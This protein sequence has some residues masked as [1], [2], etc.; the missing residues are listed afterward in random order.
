LRAVKKVKI[1]WEGEKSVVENAAGKL[2]DLARGFFAAGRELE[3]SEPPLEDL[4]NFRLLTK[5]FRYTLEQF[6]HCY[7]PGLGQRIDALR[8]LQQYLGEISDCATTSDLLDRRTD[9]SKPLRLRLQRRM[10]ELAAARVAN[11]RRHWKREFP[12]RRERWWMDYLGRF[13]RWRG[14]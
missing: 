11:F 9:L 12:P 6:R 5:R 1:R 7:G 8:K 3:G 13:A 14:L 4:H 10:K 2:P